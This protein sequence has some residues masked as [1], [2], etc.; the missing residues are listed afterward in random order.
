MLRTLGQRE[1]GTDRLEQAVA[2]FRSALEER[3]RDRVPLDW[4]GTTYILAYTKALIA[5]RTGDL[6]R[7]KAALPK[8]TE[9]RDV[10]R[11]GGHEAWAGYADN[12]IAAIEAIIGRLSGDG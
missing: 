12:A 4:A 3:A 5:E 11:D 8:A 7:A 10:L 9:A 6:A 2:A 1:T